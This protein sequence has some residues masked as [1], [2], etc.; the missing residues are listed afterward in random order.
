MI[1]YCYLNLHPSVYSWGPVSIMQLVEITLCS[2]TQFLFSKLVRR[3]HFTASTTIRFCSHEWV[4]VNSMWVGLWLILIFIIF[5][6]ILKLVLAVIFT[7]PFSLSLYMVGSGVFGAGGIHSHS[8]LE[9]CTISRHCHHPDTEV[10]RHD[11][12]TTWCPCPMKS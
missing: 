6:E 5:W 1:F 2:T 8:S 7:L 9:E 11:S 12:I 3:M 4:L 10:E